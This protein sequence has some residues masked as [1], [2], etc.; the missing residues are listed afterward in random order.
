MG[1]GWGA[2]KVGHPCR[3]GD[4]DGSIQGRI[5]VFVYSSSSRERS[6]SDSPASAVT[7]TGLPS[8]ASSIVAALADSQ[9]LFFSF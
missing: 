1:W 8:P 2:V 3:G 9:G 7:Q 6:A 5:F 4:D